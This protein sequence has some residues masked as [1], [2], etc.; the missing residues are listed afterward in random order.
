MNSL[1]QTTDPVVLSYAE[2]L[3]RDAGIEWH[4]A[5]SNMSAVEGSIGIFPRRVLVRDEQWSAARRILLDAGL[6]AWLS[7]STPA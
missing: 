1:L 3:L 2:A 6:G 4:V 5:D 7:G